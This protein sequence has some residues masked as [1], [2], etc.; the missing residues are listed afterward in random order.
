MLMGG[1][2]FSVR[3]TSP[4]IRSNIKSLL[5]RTE[6]FLAHSFYSSTNLTTTAEKKSLFII[7]FSFQVKNVDLN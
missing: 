6:N 5:D 7:N 3:P 2:R 1:E 4:K